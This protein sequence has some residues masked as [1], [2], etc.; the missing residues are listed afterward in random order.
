MAKVVF[1]NIFGFFCRLRKRSWECLIEIYF[2]EM[3]DSSSQSIEA[4]IVCRKSNKSRTVTSCTDCVA[5]MRLRRFAVARGK[6]ASVSRRDLNFP[7]LSFWRS[8]A[9]ALTCYATL[10]LARA[11]DTKTAPRRFFF[12]FSSIIEKNIRIITST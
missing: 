3:K 4:W 6:S 12:Q 11:R 10:A 8:H 9:F 2:P 5:A 1:V 7:P